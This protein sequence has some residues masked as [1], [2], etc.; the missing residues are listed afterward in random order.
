MKGQK[1]LIAG[2]PA[3]LAQLKEQAKTDENL[4][5]LLSCE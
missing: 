1:G 4:K 5:D 2:A 3:L